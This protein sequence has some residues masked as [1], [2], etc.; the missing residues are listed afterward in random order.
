[1]EQKTYKIYIGIDVS[2]AKLDI[3]FDDDSS[4]V[5]I[6]NTKKS[7][8]LLNRYFPRDKQQVLI[9]L[10][11]T[12]G[13]EK[14][15]VKWL[16]SRG[17]PV[18]ILNAKR[19]RDFAKS[20]GQFAKNDS[21]DAAMIRRYGQVFT[22]NIH[23]EEQKGELE[24]QIEDLNRRRN[25]LIS[26]RSTEKRHL[27]SIQ[28]KDGRNSIKRMIKLL[29][30]ELKKIEEKLMAA[31]EQD[32][33]LLA[34]AEL[35]MTTKGVG[36]VT[37]YSLIGELPELGKVSHKKIAALAGVAPYCRDSGTLKGKR[38]IWGGRT[39]VRT[40]LY[41]A[42]LS[43][44]KFNPAIKVFYDRLIAKGKTKKVAMVACMRKLLIIMNAM[45]K[46]NEPWHTK[47]A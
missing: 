23:I 9:L 10:E 46:N 1:M 17:I 27:A 31:L 16:L 40:A 2:K 47:I 22:Q 13:Y 26:L 11:A 32:N 15:V 35:L 33:E 25:Q 39:Q 28:N 43:A 20:S 45:V 41:M 19:V 6:E 12:G 42:T 21:I 37:T 24:E 7:F 8:K 18:A 4:V 38:T 36:L 34:K 14:A 30:K 44:K 3:K 5:T 29:D